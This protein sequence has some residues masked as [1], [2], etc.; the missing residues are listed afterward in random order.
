MLTSL[1]PNLLIVDDVAD[2]IELLAACLQDFC[3]LRFS[4]SGPECLAMVQ[5]SPPDLILLDVMM[6]GMDGYEVCDLLKH[7]PKT[8][9]IPVIFVTA[10][11]DAESESRALAGGAIDF[12]HKPINRDVVRARVRRTLELE[13]A[14]GECLNARNTLAQ[15]VEERTAAL[16][17]ALSRAEKANEAKSDFLANMSHELRTPLNGILGMANLL[18]RKLQDAALLPYV[19]HIDT[20]GQRL[21]NVVNS[22]LEAAYLDARRY[23]VDAQD[24]NL[25][26]ML[27]TCERRIQPKLQKKDLLLVREIDPALPLGLHGDPLRIAQVLNHVLDN[28]EKFSERGCITL[29]CR[30]RG[31]S[32]HG[33]LVV[34]EIEDQ[35]A[36]ISTEQQQRIFNLFEQGD[37]SSTRKF[38]GCGLGLAISRCLVELMSGQLTLSSQPGQGCLV[39]IV[40]PLEMARGTVSEVV[41]PP[42]V[43][44]VQQTLNYLQR[45]LAE[46]DVAAVGVWQGLRSLLNVPDVAVLDVMDSAIEAYDFDAARQALNRI[47]VDCPRFTMDCAPGAR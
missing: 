9:E 16:R 2:N 21:L 10:R 24:F 18:G 23:Q 1:R 33:M 28:A 8:R 44:S 32:G 45:L 31:D 14:K 29:R 34:F 36:G 7:D 37:N 41:G 46:D 11:T 12:I 35:G 27:E 22:M 19:T 47:L 3:E 5:E 40:L 13:E 17:D 43:A 39:R 26:S 15:Q 6:P 42:A 25:L 30:K 38:G 20:S 4:L